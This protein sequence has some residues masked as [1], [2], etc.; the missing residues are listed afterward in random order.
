[1]N[2]TQ[3]TNHK[4]SVVGLDVSLKGL[5]SS[6]ED[7]TVRL[8][9]LRNFKQQQIIKVPGNQTGHC[10]FLNEH[11]VLVAVANELCLYDLRAK[12]VITDF[13]A[14]RVFPDDLND[15]DLQHG[16]IAVPADDGQVTL[17]AAVDLSLIA[18][19]AKSHASLC[20]VARFLNQSLV[21][22]GHDY[23]LMEWSD[24]QLQQRKKTSV[25]NFLPESA[26]QQS[27]LNP[28]FVQCL[29]TLFTAPNRGLL[30]G[31]LGDGSMILLDA[32]DRLQTRSSR[33]TQVEAHRSAI[34]SCCFAVGCGVDKPRVWSVGNDQDLRLTKAWVND[35]PE[36]LVKLPSKPNSIKPVSENSVAVS[37]VDGNIY[38]YQ[39]Y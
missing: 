25:T 21:T 15:F 32:S 39:I 29:E 6:S 30:V 36:I 3:L 20:Y 18:Q 23:L 1:M 14:R 16:R 38:L 19:S 12:I 2:C 5:L 24:P 35:S 28:P 13:L 34:S 22:G 7:G 27:T 9:D 37:A 31:G 26:D 11:Q 17:L 8:W 10:R 4:D 33:W